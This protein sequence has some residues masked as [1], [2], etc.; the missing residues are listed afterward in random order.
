MRKTTVILYTIPAYGHV[1]SLLYLMESLVNHG[2]RVICYASETF[3]TAVEECGCEY[4][5]YPAGFSQVDLSDGK[6]IL[7]LYRLILEYTWLMVKKLEAEAGE[8][9]ADFVIYDSLALWGRGVSEVMDIPGI[10]FYSI[11]AVN[12]IISPAFYAYMQGFSTEFLKY[13]TELPKA[14]RYRRLL[15]KQHSLSHLGLMGVLMNKGELNILGYSRAFQPGGGR[16]GRGYLFLGP[17]ACRRKAMEPNS[18]T[19]PKERLIYCSMG[20]IFNEDPEFLEA[21]IQQLGGTG[22]HV[23]LTGDRQKL[24]RAG[25]PENFTVVPFANQREIFEYASLFITSGGLNS[26]HEALMYGVPCLGYPQQGEQEL[27]IKRIE[28]LGFGCCLKHPDQLLE[29]AERLIKES[30]SRNAEDCRSITADHMEELWPLL[31]RLT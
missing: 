8:E 18:F 22:Y 29:Q 21:V 6:R 19:Y 31:R 27:N 25:I 11:V 16:F 13:V 10:S 20:T 5:D 28:K 7:K 24:E 23:V 26:I 9:E 14:F 15:K 1:F 30:E 3:R 12:K 2:F 17:G 4:R